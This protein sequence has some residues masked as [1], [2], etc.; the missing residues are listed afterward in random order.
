M[1]INPRNPSERKVFS[2]FPVADPGNADQHAGYLYVV[3]G[4][5][6]YEAIA[7]EVS[8]SYKQRMVMTVILL[9]VSAAFVAGA[10]LFSFLTRRLRLLT[11]ELSEFADG[12]FEAD[13]PI[14]AV[15]QPIDEIDQLRNACNY[16]A[17]TIQKQL[18][19]LQDNER[20]RRELVTNI[21]HDLR[22]PLTTMQGYIETL[23]IKDA[24]LD[25]QTRKTYLEIARK[26]AAHLGKLIQVRRWP[27]ASRVGRCR[28]RKRS[29]SSCRSPRGWRRRTRRA[30]C[31]AI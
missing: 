4:G 30:S 18:S 14:A 22:T 24:E 29:A 10:L 21:S 27:I 9:L 1:G 6:Q 12:H 3:L 26:H 16:M 23:I 7:K 19:S 25:P 28:W 15:A 17:M 5:A 31:I 13:D 20:L 11:T 8:G 2:A